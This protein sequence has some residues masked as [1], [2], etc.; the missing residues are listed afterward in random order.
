MVIWCNPHTC[1]TKIQE[2]FGKFYANPVAFTSNSLHIAL[3]DDH[4]ASSDMLPIYTSVII[5]N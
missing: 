3:I 2:C 5:G 1:P 4:I